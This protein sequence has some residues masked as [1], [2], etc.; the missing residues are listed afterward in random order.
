MHR[1]NFLLGGLALP[2]L[3]R[4]EKTGPRPNILL[5]VADGLGSWMLGCG[6]NKEIRTP[7]IDQLAQ[8]GTRFQNHLAC[9][10]SSSPSLATLLT[11]RVPRQHG[12]QDFLTGEPVENPPQGQAAAPASFH[13]EVM[14]SDVLAGL[15]Y[16]CGFVGEW[17][18]GDDRA[19]QHG[20]KYWYTIDGLGVYQDPHMNG[21]GQSVSEKG[22]LTDLITAKAGEFCDKQTSGKP[23]FLMVRYLNPHPPYDGHPA[24][25][26]DM[27]AKA[28][29]DSIG[30]EPASPNLLRGKEYFQNPVASLRKAAAGITA[31]DDQIPLLL[32][33]LQQR[34]L[35]DDTAIVITS[36]NGHFLGRHGL[37][38]GGRSSEPIS[39]YDDVVLA[40]MIWH[41][42][43]HV[44]AQNVRPEVVSA[45]D[46][47]PTVCGLLDVP[48]PE[49]RNLCGRSYHLPLTNKPWPKKMSW[50]RI[51]FGNYR[52][53]EMAR[54]E[55]YKLVL[56]NNGNGPNE[57]FDLSVDPRERENQYESPK[58]LDARDWMRKAIEGWRGSTSG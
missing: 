21:N 24:R 38:T 53:T 7:N 58:Y 16:E 32:A 20:F 49:G 27:Y 41:W 28:E 44:P 10:P 33:K 48:T 31:L 14:L 11:G 46:F 54:D 3:A 4:K 40:P 39:M 18:L 52:N 57:F 30:W 5:V 26:Y 45:Y 23:F 13:N 55:R 37:W 8:S 47:L 35:R 51:T 15:G 19:P 22:Y 1:R 2:A 43:G 9:T 6:G 25:Y 17:N 50:R 56:R 34:G 12:I 29:F 42:L 36:S